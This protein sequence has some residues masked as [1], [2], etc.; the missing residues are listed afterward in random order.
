MIK[1]ILFLYLGIISLAGISHAQTQPSS[2]ITYPQTKAVDTITDYFGNKI[3]DPYRWLEAEAGDN[4]EVRSWINAQNEITFN[5]LSKIPY[6]EQIKH[7]LTELADYPRQSAPYRAGEF[8]FYTK[9]DGLQNQSVIYYREGLNGDEKVFIDPNK[10]SAEGTVTENLAG[11][12][13]DRKYIAITQAKS[14]SDWNEIYVREV[15]SNKLLNDKIEWSKFSGAAWYKDGFFYSGYDKPGENTY[16]GSSENQK[17]FYHKL[18]TPQSEDK[19][20]YSDIENPKY[21]FGAQTTED[22]RYLLINVSPGTYGTEIWWKDLRNDSDVFKLLF[23]GFESEYAV[24][25]NEGDNLIVWTNHNAPNFKVVLVDPKNSSPESWKTIIAEQKEPLENVSV[26]GGKI[27]AFYLK[28]VK[29]V[30]NQYSRT[31]NIFCRRYSR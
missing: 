23:K 28:D 3:S 11:F 26:A 24:L 2:K 13:N 30:I 7:R 10:L 17:I 21:Y 14:G 25:D 31:G 15:A 22:E 1:S 6:R 29:P 16:T 4:D 27:F 20:I 19:L 9:N 8:Y 12:S 5:Y 18:G